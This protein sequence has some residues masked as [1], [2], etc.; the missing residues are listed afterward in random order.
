MFYAAESDRMNYNVR[1]W[2]P[3]K[4]YKKE[5]LLE[6]FMSVGVISWIIH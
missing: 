6:N 4:M 2:P 3:F 1:P 5:I